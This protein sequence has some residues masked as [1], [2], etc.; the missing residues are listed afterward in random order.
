M[1]VLLAIGAF[2]LWD[3]G[4]FGGYWERAGSL[5]DPKLKAFRCLDENGEIMED[6]V[7]PC[8]VM[9]GRGYKARERRARECEKK[10]GNHDACAQESYDWVD[11][12]RGYSSLRTMKSR[13][14]LEKCSRRNS[15]LIHCES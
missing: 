3:E 5:Y 9:T 2:Y 15:A 1:V 6:L 10:G 13:F 4:Y 14:V 7:P 11:S 12:T 8:L